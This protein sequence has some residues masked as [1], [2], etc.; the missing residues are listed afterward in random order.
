MPRLLL[1]LLTLLCSSQPGLGSDAAP[2][3]AG[4]AG[5]VAASAANYSSM[6]MLDDTRKLGIGDRVSYRVNQDKELD[7]QLVVTDS[8]ELEIPYYGRVKAV[9]KTCKALAME[10]K[11]NLEKELYIEATVILAVDLL[12]KKR[13]SVYLAG[14]VRNMGSQDIPSDEVFTLT[15][16][17]LKAG[18]F[19]DFADKKR[20]KVTRQPPVGQ[21]NSLVFVVDVEQI[22]EKG[23]T[24][25][26]MKL[27]PGDLILVPSR[28]INF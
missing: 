10:V 1:I 11:A 14:Q 6:D 19:G 27:E 16:A 28:A 26:D 22:F 15:K 20:V 23:K 18:G 12:N 4:D 7:K 5:P 3:A 2:A 25:K 8:G 17:I 13:G 21:A 9:E 24:E